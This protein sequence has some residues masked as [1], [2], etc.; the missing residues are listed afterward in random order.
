M[1]I[2]TGKSIEAAL[3]TL[4]A[5]SVYFA[6]VEDKYVRAGGKFI[7]ILK[8]EPKSAIA[9]DKIRSYKIKYDP[10]IIYRNELNKRKKQLK[11]RGTGR[12]IGN[13]V[14]LTFLTIVEVAALP[15][16]F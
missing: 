11:G 8:E 4:T 3:D 16:G 6:P 5:D 14:G 9:F 13:I 7:K 2:I 12:V 10:N 1:E 15:L